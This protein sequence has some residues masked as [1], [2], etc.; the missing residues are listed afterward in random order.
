MFENKLI[1]LNN[2]Y[3][4][5]KVTQKVVFKVQDAMGNKCKLLMHPE[6]RMLKLIIFVVFKS[7]NV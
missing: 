6:Q 7:N 4:C 5:K 1:E 3:P 2:C